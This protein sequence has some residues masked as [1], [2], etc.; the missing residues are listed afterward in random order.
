MSENEWVDDPTFKADD[1]EWVDDPT[2]G[3]NPKEQGTGERWARGALN[4]L[5]AAGAM[6]GGAAGTVMG[7]PA[8][9]GAIATGIAGAGLGMAA[10]E[11]LKNIGEHFLGDDKTR[12]EIYAG[13]AKAALEGMTYE[14]GGQMLGKGVGHLAEKAQPFLEDTGEGARKMAKRFGARALGA[15]RGTIKKLGA[16]KVESLGGYAL[17]EGLL[18]PLASTDDVIARNAA[19]KAEGAAKMNEA[20]SAIDD[21]GASLFNPLDVAT[22]VD[23]EIGGFYR[24]PINRGE[25]NQLENTLESI[26]MRGGDNIPLKDAQAL[27]QELGKVANWKNN[28]SVTEKERMAR[29]AYG[30][31]SSS[32]DD[33]A[34]AGANIIGKDG[35]ADVLKHG[36]KLYGNAKGAEDLLTN[37]LAREQGNSLMGLTD[38]IAGTGAMGAMGPAGMGVVAAK[39]GIERF[40]AQNAALGLDKIAKALMKSPQMAAQA[41][42][43]PSA[44]KSMVQ[45]LGSRAGNMESAPMSMPRAADKDNGA[46]NFQESSGKEALLQKTQGSKYGQVLQNAAKNGDDSLAAAHFVLSQRDPEYRKITEGE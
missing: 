21:A 19:K 36:K 23:N 3:K 30:I 42:S 10:G 14:M 9:P 12:E 22:K 27:K 31:V 20:Y 6:F 40:G 17:D 32:I 43:N 35:I 15:E 46:T 1:A 2:F 37:K 38:H 18:S 33:A 7:V 25:T 28:V 26:L 44:F 5:P 45:M 24:S 29:E 41:Q 4:A 8:G 13:P 11:S 39:K 16:D 34:E